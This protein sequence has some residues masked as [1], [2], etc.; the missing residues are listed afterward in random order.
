MLGWQI[1]TDTLTSVPDDQRAALAGALDQ[2]CSNPMAPGLHVLPAKGRVR[3]RGNTQVW[4]VE[5]PFSWWLSYELHPEGLMPLAQPIVMV[6][7]FL[8]VWG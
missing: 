6:R 5:L 3:G 2:F 4:L 8:Q 7:N 1:V